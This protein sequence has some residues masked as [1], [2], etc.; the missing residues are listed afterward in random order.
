M[1][2]LQ[3]A[4]A[5]AAASSPTGTIVAASVRIDRTEMSLRTTPHG[6]ANPFGEADAMPHA[7]PNLQA[8]LDTRERVPI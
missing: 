2:P 8:T 7:A 3:Q 4:S 6:H 5:P 1:I